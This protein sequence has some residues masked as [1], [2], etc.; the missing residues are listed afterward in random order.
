MEKEEEP[1]QRLSLEIIP[2]ILV[3]TKKE[4]L[5]KK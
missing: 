4:F 2:A 5:E 3:K 1:A